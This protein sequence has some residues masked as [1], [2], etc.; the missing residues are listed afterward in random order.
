VYGRKLGLLKKSP[1]DGHA[2]IS[3]AQSISLSEAVTGL[4]KLDHQNMAVL[5]P[6]SGAGRDGNK[7]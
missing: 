3:C 7:L 2:K 6:A 4:S 5:A 1:E